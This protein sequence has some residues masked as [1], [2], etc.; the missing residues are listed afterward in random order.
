M[1]TQYKRH[2]GNEFLRCFLLTIACMNA[3]ILAHHINTT[4]IQRIYWFGYVNLLVLIVS[5][6][7]T[8]AM[9]SGL[10]HYKDKP[11]LYGAIVNICAAAVLALIL[12]YLFV[13]AI[14][15]IGFATTMKWFGTPHL[16]IITIIVLSLIGSI[17]CL[18]LYKQ[19][20]RRNKALSENKLPDY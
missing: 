4:I 13:N 1:N 3:F 16:W 7:S 19:I 17:G 11:L 18:K 5:F 9:V 10:G 15:T 6:F 8:F 12:A 2:T 20:Q 14:S